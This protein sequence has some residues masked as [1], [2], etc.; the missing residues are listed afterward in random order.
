MQ[1]LPGQ[2]LPGTAGERGL[3]GEKVSPT[4]HA[5]SKRLE[6]RIMINIKN[7]LDLL[8]FRVSEETKVLLASEE[9]E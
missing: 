3:A 1:G 5:L 8:S 4:Q 6:T 2:T 7:I 9:K